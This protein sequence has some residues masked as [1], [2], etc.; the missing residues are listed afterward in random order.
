MGRNKP[1]KI[2]AGQTAKIRGRKIKVVSVEPDPNN[3]DRVV[4]FGR[5][6]GKDR[7]ITSIQT[8]VKKDGSADPPTQKKSRWA[9]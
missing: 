3:K 6:E 7:N 9:R 8:S 5:G 4:I 2:R 1:P